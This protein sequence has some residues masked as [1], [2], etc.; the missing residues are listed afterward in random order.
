MVW[1]GQLKCE[2][3]KGDGGANFW[4]GFW[5]YNIILPSVSSNLFNLKDIKMLVSFF[6][7]FYMQYI[8]IE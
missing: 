3:T 5:S 6:G 2:F 8:I 7:E 1:S 4:Y